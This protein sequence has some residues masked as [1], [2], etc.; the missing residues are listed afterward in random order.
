MC[1]DIKKTLLKEKNAAAAFFC[2]KF[3]NLSFVIK[4]APKARDFFEF[5]T[6]FDVFLNIWQWRTR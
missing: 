1:Q 6:F 5:L 3:K 4:S 2:V